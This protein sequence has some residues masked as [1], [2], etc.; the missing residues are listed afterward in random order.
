[1][2]AN[3]KYWIVWMVSE[4]I[5]LFTIKFIQPLCEPCLPEQYCPPCISKEQIYLFWLAIGLGAVFFIWQ[6]VLVV[7]RLKLKG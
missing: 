5:I 3:Y 7:K 4:M 6:L 1:M 2:N